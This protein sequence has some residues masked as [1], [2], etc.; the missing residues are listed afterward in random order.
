MNTNQDT[1]KFLIWSEGKE[2]E[3]YSVYDN[4]RELVT[5]YEHVSKESS[6]SWIPFENNGHVGMVRWDSVTRVEL[7]DQDVKF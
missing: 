7:A 5:R 4:A 2:L 3:H 6:P 1:F